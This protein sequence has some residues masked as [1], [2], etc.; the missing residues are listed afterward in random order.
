MWRK[1]VSLGLVTVILGIWFASWQGYTPHIANLKKFNEGPGQS[2][3]DIVKENLRLHL[4]NHHHLMVEKDRL[5]VAP[6]ERGLFS[7]GT[8]Y[9]VFFSAKHEDRASEGVDL[10]TMQV[11]MGKN[12]YPITFT[13]P[14]NLTENPLSQDLIFDLQY[15]EGEDQRSGAHLLFG[16]RDAQGACRSVSYL[17]WGEVDRKNN[18]SEGNFITHR[19]R[20]LMNKHFFDRETQPHWLVIRFKSPLPNCSAAWLSS[21]PQVNAEGEDQDSIAKDRGL[22]VFH[23]YSGKDREISVDVV[24]ESINPI[25]SNIEV[26]KPPKIQQHTLSA[27]QETLRVYDLLNL[28]EDLNLSALQ[29][30]SATSFERNLYEVLINEGDPSQH[31]P[32]DEVSSILDGKRPTWYPPRIDVKSGFPSEG[33]WRPI[34]VRA[35]GEPLLLKTFVR[36]DAEHPY[37]SIHLYAM[38][39]R[40]LGLRFVA[41]GDPQQK[42]L[43]GVGSGKINLE[44][45]GSV[46][47]AFNG[48]PILNL[49]QTGGDQQNDLHGIIQDQHLLVAPTEGLPTI[50][51][52]ARGRLAMGRLDVDQ[53]PMVW[54]SLRQS[55][56]PLVDLRIRDRAFVPPQSPKGRLDKLHIIRS[57]IGINQQGTLIYAWSPA[58]TSALLAQAMRLV[59]VKFAMSLSSS[60]TQ[61]G[62]AIYPESKI[63]GPLG[64]DRAVHYKMELDPQVWHRGSDRDFFY[65]VLAQSLPRSFPQRP[66][67]WREGEGAWQMVQHQDVNPWLATSFVRADHVG[68]DVELLRIDSERLQV[69]LSLG[70]HRSAKFYKE[71]RPLPAEPVARVP[72]GF[73]TKRLGLISVN[74]TYQA[75][76]LGKMT[77]AV[78]DRGRSVLGRWGQGDLRVDGVW[79]DLLQ[80][81]ALID[82]GESLSLKENIPS[83]GLKNEKND[84]EGSISEIHAETHREGPVAAIGVTAESDLIF[85]Y[86]QRGDRTALQSAMRSAGVINA[87][88]INYTGTSDTGRHQFFYRY[89]GQTFYNSYPDLA[90]KPANLQSSKSALIGFDDALIITPKAALPRAR[91]VESFKE[92]ND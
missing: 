81:E 58:T 55:Y 17:H 54:S 25:K 38:D 24:T 11:K 91:F 27:L 2:Y 41:G 34:K 7:A 78:D 33:E 79:Q 72:F 12:A 65:L 13:P 20:A 90:L 1:H 57:A 39:M 31:R 22:D 30:Q 92:L 44:D 75:P 29:A 69:N 89:L 47:A 19:L 68:N 83:G 70:G 40:R 35:E 49:L 45:K 5:L 4:N 10:Y 6:T 73:G 48:G 87:L 16:Q 21:T 84:I 23:I 77:W 37:H 80:G 15:R 28:D 46:I 67:N 64:K 26:I 82:Q 85:A 36:L 62:L 66:A 61:N 88:R 63:E 43:E 74:E 8:P 32:V 60:P 86:A 3:S 53:L 42:S 52:D 71:E 59:G 76:I 14:R 9:L 56:A 18:E 50:A 51:V